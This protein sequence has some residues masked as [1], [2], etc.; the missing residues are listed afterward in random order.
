MK[1]F[2]LFVYR[3]ED[4]R[5]ADLKPRISFNFYVTAPKN[6]S[7]IIPR[8]E[9]EEA[10]RISRSRINDA[11]RL[12]DNS[13]EFLGIQPTLAPPYQPPVTIWLIVFGVVMAVIVA[14]IVVLI[15]TGIRDRKKKN[16]ARNEENPYA[17]IDISKGENNP[18][19][20]NTDDVQ[21]SF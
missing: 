2:V 14:G 12:N 5:V 6:V 19:F 1:M 11:F 16:Q 18:G 8:T 3:E 20:Q 9:V 7:D 21:T 10:I 15:F 4:V 13:L 17:S